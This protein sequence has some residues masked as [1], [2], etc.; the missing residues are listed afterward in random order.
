[1]RVGSTQSDYNNWYYFSFIPISDLEAQST[2]MKGFF[3]ST[4]VAFTV[5]F[6]M[7]AWLTSH[8]ITKPIRKMAIAMK[9]PNIDIVDI[10]MGK[11]SFDEIAHLQSAFNRMQRRIDE[12]ITEVRIVSEKE[13]EAEVRAL[14][15]Q[16]NPHVLYNT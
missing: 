10:P 2:N 13:R 12:L 6:V 14:H 16:I 3:I 4:I 15:A 7:L 1:Y 11:K 9:R 8:F 5:L